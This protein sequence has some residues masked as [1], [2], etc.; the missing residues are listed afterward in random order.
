MTQKN[1]ETIKEKILSLMREISL[2]WASRNI[3]V[4]ICAE[5]DISAMQSIYGYNDGY[6]IGTVV[7][8]SANTKAINNILA[9]TWQELD[10]ST[11]ENES[12]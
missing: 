2:Q 1:P 6:G 9:A 4:I 3:T 10:N 5:S 7:Y 11:S 12:I 8:A